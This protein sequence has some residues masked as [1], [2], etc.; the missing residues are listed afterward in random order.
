[1]K[2]ITAAVVG[3]G[4]RGEVYSRFALKSPDKLEI[5]AV[6]DPDKRRRDLAKELFSIPEENCFSDL[7]QF[8]GRGR[9][10]DCVINGTMDKQHI[11]T[12]LPLLP[13]GY[14]VLL[15][16]PITADKSELLKLL[17]ESK[18]HGNKIMIC[19]VLR[20]A[21][22][23]NM[24]MQEIMSGNI[25]KVRHIETAENV[26]VAH[27]SISFIRGKWNNKK[28]CGSS[29]LLQ[30]CCHDLDIIC[31]LNSQT[32]PAYVSS[33]GSR[34]HFVPENAPE[35]AGT[36]CLV[37]CKIEDSC[38]YSC[39]YMHLNKNPM[40]ITVWADEE[41]NYKDITLE[42]R[43]QY[44]KS[45]NPHGRCIYKTEADVV[46]Q[47]GT[48]IK[49]ADGTTAYHLLYSSAM[50][51]GRRIKVYGTAG[52]IEG[53]SEENKFEVRNYNKHTIEYTRREM[54]IPDISGENHHGGDSRL[55]NDFLCYINGEKSFATSRLEDSVLSHL[56]V[57]A[58][59]ESME[60]GKL[61]N[62]E[63]L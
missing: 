54:R 13:L 63:A 4:D 40:P 41:K 3:F 61:V 43:E 23:Y 62:I 37:D 57:Y 46:D 49:F 15:E 36:R 27:S 28:L 30:K 45:H 6:V 14:D 12:T 34:I 58:A 53:Y 9:I 35:G 52:E 20:F 59:D 48:M 55:M 51:A 18:K 47:Q 8:L 26:G 25:G 7:S 60:T 56:C 1:M 29:Y 42:E 31:W 22:F 11:E 5:T 38:M 10:A 19:H 16:K 39:R 2:K 32:V 24:I 50:R 21:P 17:N 33:I 44:L